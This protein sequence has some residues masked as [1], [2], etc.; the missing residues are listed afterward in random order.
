MK[1]KIYGH[2]LVFISVFLWS[3]LY[4]SV[5]Y[6]L[7]FFSPL[8]LLIFQF[9]IGYVFLW[10]WKP[11]ILTL[12]NKREEFL[13]MIAGISGISVYNL[14]L[15][16]AMDLSYASN[17]SVIIATAPLWSAIFS[18]IFKIDKPYI[19]FFIGFVLCIVGISLL[20][21]N[22]EIKVSIL[23]DTFAIIS[24]LG[25]GFYSVC[26][27]KIN[28]LGYN[29]ILSTRR[30]VFYGIIFILPSLFFLDFSLNIESF[31][32]LSVCLNLIFLSIFASGA[33]FV[34]FNKATNLI[35]VIKTN[36]YVYLTPIITIFTS[37]IVLNESLTMMAIVGVCLTL[38]GVIISEYRH[39]L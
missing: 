25:W 1:S 15:N 2:I 18:F 30:I 3:S 5:K 34:M 12:H 27:S 13:F 33:C 20:S 16:L 19:N 24:A 8:E 32:S 37:M 39:K 23:G 22:G 11:K 26:V 31:S 14:F 4:V 7:D 35:G 9:I 17:V 28:A 10:I 36:I 38:L 6:L 29:L 21:F